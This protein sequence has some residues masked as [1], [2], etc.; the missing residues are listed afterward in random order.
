MEYDKI[1]SDLLNRDEYLLVGKKIVRS[2]ALNKLL[3]RTRFT[4][5]Y[6]PKGTKAVRVLRSTQPH[7]LIKRVD[8]SAALQMPGVEAILTAKDITGEN[9]IGYALPEQP[10]LNDKKVHY[11]G[12][13]IA[14]IIA[15]DDVAT[16][17]ATDAIEVEYEPLPPVFEVDE[18]MAPG[19]PFIHKDGNVAL[20]T[21]IRKGD[22]EKGWKQ[23][24]IVIEDI[25]RTPFQEHMALEPEAA[26]AVPEGIDKVTVIA[27]MQSPHVVREKVAR[28]LGWKLNQVRIIQAMTGGAFGKKDDTGP[29]ISAYAAFAAM[30]I[31]KPVAY[32]M[33]RSEVVSVTPKR[34][35][36]RFKYK[37]GA[38][39]KGKMTAVEVEITLEVGAYANRAPFWLWRQT[40]HA[41]GPYEVDNVAVD[42][43]AVYTNKVYGGS[44]RGFG[45][46]AL[47]F[48]VEQQVDKLAYELGMDPVEF[49][50]KNILREGSRTTCDQLL[51]N[52]V[53][54]E[55]CLMGV[56]EA[57]EWT[58]HK[59]PVRNG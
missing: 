49:R 22:I 10:F 36:A 45:N 42:G 3:G 43:K 52:S 2:D 5:D 41:C 31:G 35:P 56:A 9:E 44:Y 55:K 16:Q 48:A 32:V 34:F 17:E 58:K 8:I 51:D 23:A 1:L 13:P 7:A 20:T 53:G 27:C 39:R 38:D 30:K 50:M 14:L 37:S 15:S 18:A 19:A 54:M 29:L 25:Y 28:V 21:R 47:H 24:K 4:A 46:L 26:Y 57:S 33:D 12:D 11:V 6:I 59:N 40:A